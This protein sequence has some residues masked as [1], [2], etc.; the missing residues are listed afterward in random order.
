MNR[1]LFDELDKQYPD[2]RRIH[3]LLRAGADINAVEQSR[4]DFLTAF[5]HMHRGLE[6]HRYHW[7]IMHPFWGTVNTEAKVA[8]FKAHFYPLLDILE[9]YNFD[10]M[11]GTMFRVRPDGTKYGHMFAGFRLLDLCEFQIL[12]KYDMPRF[13]QFFERLY[14]GRGHHVDDATRIGIPYISPLLWCATGSY[15][16]VLV[17]YFIMK[18]ARWNNPSWAQPGYTA[19][20]TE[21]GANVPADAAAAMIIKLQKQL[22]VNFITGPQGANLRGFL[23]AAYGTVAAVDILEKALGII[24][25][26]RRRAALLHAPKVYA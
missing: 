17:F 6:L 3:A 14:F 23:A 12:A 1:Q 9:T 11:N 24:A 13:V 25:I 22:G 8:A 7:D 2:I 16:S 15:T 10:V 21:F 19:R 5:W 26:E 20:L 18:G 4:S